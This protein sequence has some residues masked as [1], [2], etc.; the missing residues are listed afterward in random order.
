MTTVVV[1]G[2]SFVLYYLLLLHA[3]L[4]S[5]FSSTLNHRVVAPY[6][7]SAARCYGF[8]TPYP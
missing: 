3:S 4:S 6:H 5:S 8:P 2:A 7:I 1:V